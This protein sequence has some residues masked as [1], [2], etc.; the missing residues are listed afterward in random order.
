METLIKSITD[1]MKE[2]MSLI[3]NDKKEPNGQSKEEKKKKREER[4]KQ[5][6]DEPV[7]KHCNKKHPA[8]AEDE[9]WELEKNK[10]FCP[11]NWKSAKSN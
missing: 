5:Y 10:D 4:R 6:N 11:T 1:A 2:M 8:K 7:C 9:C 3:K